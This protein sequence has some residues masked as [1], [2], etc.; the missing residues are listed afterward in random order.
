MSY[1]DFGVRDFIC[2]PSFQDWILD[3]GGAQAVF[4]E[5]WL[6][7]HPEKAEEIE[8]ARLLLQSMR[9]TEHHPDEQMVQASLAEVLDSIRPGRHRLGRAWRMAAMV[10]GI[11]LCT[12]LGYYLL[13]RQP[14]ERSYATVYGETQTIYLPDSSRLVLNAHS[15]V[16]YNNKDWAKGH[17][18]EVWLDGEAFFDVHPQA[19]A[20][21]LVHTRDLTVE[22]LGTAFDIRD[23]RGKTEVVLQ[24]GKIRV[25]FK[26]G[27]HEDLVMS[28]GDKIGYNP[29]EATLS[30]TVTIPES[31]TSWK[32][33][34]LTDVTVGEIAEYLEDNYHK[35]VIITDPAMAKRTI[36]GAVL[37]DNLDDA[38]FALST[39]LNANIIEQ[40]DTLIIQPR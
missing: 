7:E 2:D 29:A 14:A 27:G 10:A 35:T 39:V 1:G 15:S 21:F 26:N 37:L 3:P 22:V 36:G 30:H 38:L 23:R 32:D 18:R 25:L 13:K 11:G 12:G 17:A 40:K 33:K 24:S 20:E 8:E 28:P 34:K 6:R 4:W 9:F 5:N 31:Y 19:T 16:H